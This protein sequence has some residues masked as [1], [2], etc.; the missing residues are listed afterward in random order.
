MKGSASD[1]SPPNSTGSKTVTNFA[2]NIGLGLGYQITNNIALDVGYR[3]ADLGKVKTK[4]YNWTW[5]EPGDGWGLETKRIYQHQF[6]MGAR[7]TF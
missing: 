4:W 6:S 2:W 1:W 3:F 5:S 7:F